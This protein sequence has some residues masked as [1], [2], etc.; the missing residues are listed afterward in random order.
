MMQDD[1]A[2]IDVSRS[3]PH[4]CRLGC[5]CGRDCS[6]TGAAGCGRPERPSRWA[7]TFGP[8]GRPQ[9]ARTPHG[10]SPA[11]LA[12]RTAID[13]GWV[14]ETVVSPFH[15]LYQ[16]AL[17]FHTQ[18]RLAQSESEASRLARAALL[19]YV[20]SAEALVHQAADE[21]GRPELRGMLVDPCRPLP[22]FEAWRLLPAIVAEP[23]VPARPFD[24]ESPPWP[25]FAELL[26]L[27]D[28][29]GL[30]WAGVQ[31][32][33]LLPLGPPRR[34]LRA[35]ANCMT[36]RPALE[37]AVRQWPLAFPAPACRATPMPFA[38][39]TSTRPA[40]CWTPRS[41]P[42]TAAWAARSPKDQR[43]RREPVRMVHP[44]SQSGEL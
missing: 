19:L 14:I 18:S 38:P 15:C 26:L 36:F 6:S 39:A 10:G 22:L 27:R 29:V 5:G 12:D 23:G 20:S 2:K 16:D 30:P 3:E 8:A 33:G 13:S 24:P 1:Q 9:R 7:G 35:T 32:P 40:A 28:L 44:P 4:R 17:S 25:Q 34:R 41:R 37:R 31:S 11:A 42:S 21:L 43:H